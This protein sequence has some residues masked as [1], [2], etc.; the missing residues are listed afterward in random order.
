MGFPTPLSV[1]KR[2]FS[3]S[4]YLTHRER[5]ERGIRVTVD[6]ENQTGGGLQSDGC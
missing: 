6:S 2:F 5:R 1:K 4:L 3:S